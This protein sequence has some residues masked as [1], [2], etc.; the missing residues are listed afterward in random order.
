MLNRQLQLLMALKGKLRTKTAREDR[1]THGDW[2]WVSFFGPGAG[3]KGEILRCTVDRHVWRLCSWPVPEKS[4]MDHSDQPCAV[5]RQ[6]SFVP[7][8]R[9][10]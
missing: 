5:V 9:N 1:N 7:F 3:T 8:S 4:V 10:I 2:Q 6:Q